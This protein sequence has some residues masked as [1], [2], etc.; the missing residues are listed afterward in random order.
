MQL[1]YWRKDVI[2]EQLK[3]VQKALDKYAKEA[4]ALVAEKVRGIFYV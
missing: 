1:P 4:Q 3:N 2:R